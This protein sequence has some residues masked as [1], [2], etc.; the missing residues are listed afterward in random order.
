[1]K[2]DE[3]FLPIDGYDN[4]L[5]SSYGR[6]INVN[7]SRTLKQYDKNGRKYVTLSYNGITKHY[8]VH[9]LVAVAFIEK[10]ECSLSVR[11]IDGDKSNNY[12][13]NLEWI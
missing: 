2:E 1:M 12:Y 5:I 10:D 3:I 4:Y 9:R 7:T 8:Y 13:K 11:H 6:V